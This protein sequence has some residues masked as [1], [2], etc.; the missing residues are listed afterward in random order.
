[1]KPDATLI[2][3]KFIR[4]SFTRILNTRMSRVFYL[5]FAELIPDFFFFSFFKLNNDYENFMLGI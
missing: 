3:C 1:M 2:S 4:D 5:F